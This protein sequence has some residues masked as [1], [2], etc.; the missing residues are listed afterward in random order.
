MSIEEVALQRA[1]N[2]LKAAKVNFVIH[3]PGTA[4]I[5]AVTEGLNYA[6]DSQGF[7]ILGTLQV[8]VPIVRT[9][10]GR[11]AHIG[12]RKSWKETGYVAA[13]AALM[14][15]DTW[16]F[17]VGSREAAISLQKVVSAAGNRFL[18]TGNFTTCADDNIVAIARV[19]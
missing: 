6:I 5:I 17:T 9:K 1:T 11:K 15:G 12:P 2:L 10:S 7:G 16:K 19:L 14:P 13:I 18:G 3:K 4:E 8:A